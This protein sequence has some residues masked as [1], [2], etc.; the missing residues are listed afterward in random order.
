MP[1]GRLAQREFAQ[2]G[3][4]VHGGGFAALQAEGHLG[5]GGLGEELVVDV[6]EHH[7]GGA[8]PAF[9]RSAPPVEADR[10]L[11]L[12]LEAAQG[13]AQRGLPRAVAAGEGDDFA[14]AQVH[15]GLAHHW[16]PAVVDRQPPCR[17][18][19][20]AA[21]RRGDGVVRGRD[22]VEVARAQSHG[23][24]L[25]RTERRELAGVHDA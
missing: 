12:A 20:A 1:G 5:R 11:R 8:H 3:V 13:A 15:V 21:P 25:L 9:A 22:V 14:G 7:G 18:R 6:L 2:D 4:D 23:N 16:A 10:P 24:Q 19:D 17:E